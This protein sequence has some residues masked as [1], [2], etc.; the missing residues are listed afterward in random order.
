MR[1]GLRRANAL[2]INSIDATAWNFSRIKVPI[3]ENQVSVTFLPNEQENAISCVEPLQNQ[4]AHNRAPASEIMYFSQKV[5]DPQRNKYLSLHY[6]RA[7]EIMEVQCIS[8]P[9]RQESNIF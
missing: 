4:L 8:K 2:Q 5:T 9:G 1:R 6:V 3:T 7:V